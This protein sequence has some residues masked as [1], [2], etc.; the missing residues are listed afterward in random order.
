MRIDPRKEAEFCRLH[1]LQLADKPEAT[2]LLR[3]AE[4]FDDL[5]GMSLGASQ[6][7]AANIQVPSC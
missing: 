4:V 3:V 5:A 6:V 2:F 1:A 7:R